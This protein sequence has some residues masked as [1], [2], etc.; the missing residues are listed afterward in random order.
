MSDLVEFNKRC[1]YTL[2]MLI[3]G[4]IENQITYAKNKE[5]HHGRCEKKSKLIQNTKIKNWNSISVEFSCGV[6][7]GSIVGQ[8]HTVVLRKNTFLLFYCKLK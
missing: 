6:P 5:L 7:Q 3:V 1:E 8:P 4:C 2:P